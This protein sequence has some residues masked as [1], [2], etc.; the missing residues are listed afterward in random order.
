M[1]PLEQLIV[2]FNEFLGMMAHGMSSTSSTI[3]LGLGMF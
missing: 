1:T 2:Q 3:A